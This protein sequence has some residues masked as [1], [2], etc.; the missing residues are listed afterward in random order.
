MDKI[1]RYQKAV[2]K[3]LEEY[4]KIKP[5]NMGEVENQLIIDTNR[6]HFLI[7]QTGW[8]KDKFVHASIMHFDIKEEKIWIQCNWTELDV[9][10]ELIAQGVDK[11]DIVLGFIPK[12]ERKYTGYAA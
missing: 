7:L 2:I 5:V 4:A 10:E 9:G 1:V 8:D 6:N 11:K 3:I 12:F